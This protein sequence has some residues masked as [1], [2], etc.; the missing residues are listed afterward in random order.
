[1]PTQFFS[2]TDTRTYSQLHSNKVASLS[3]KKTENDMTNPAGQHPQNHR[4]TT[5]R[6]TFPAGPAGPCNPSDP[7]R[8]S[9]P[10]HPGSP[11]LPNGPV[12]IYIYNEYYKMVRQTSVDTGKGRMH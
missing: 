8:P 11:T 4:S 10:G 6:L 9:G 3:K 12:Y 2:Y 1:M 7:R 5:K